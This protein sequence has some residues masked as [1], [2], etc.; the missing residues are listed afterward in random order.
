MSAAEKTF[1]AILAELAKP[2]D[3]A[4][5]EFKPGAVA[6]NAERALAL[7]YV[8]SREY[9]RRLDATDPT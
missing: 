9:M 6:R 1:A 7:A 4:V 8:D 2:F 3:P 5:V